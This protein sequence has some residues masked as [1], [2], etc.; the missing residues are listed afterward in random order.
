[1]WLQFQ[2]KF[3]PQRRGFH[4][5]TKEILEQLDGLE[6]IKIGILHLF[7]QH[8]S[9]SLTLNEN[10]D[11]TV[12]EDFESFFND[13]VSEDKSYYIHNY[14]GP[15]DMPAH[16]KSSLLGSSIS[17]PIANGRLGLGHWQGIYL[18]EHRNFSTSRHAIATM[19]GELKS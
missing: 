15:D 16:L 8:T 18:C 7:L 4:L 10:A 17:I 12:R 2:I 13:V 6:N 19:Q 9:A 5:V 1:M 14:E 3:K 11:P